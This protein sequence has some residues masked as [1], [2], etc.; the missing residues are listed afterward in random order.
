MELE[1]GTRNGIGAGYDISGKDLRIRGMKPERLV[2][3]WI[4][5]FWLF[6]YTTVFES[7]WKGHGTC[8]YRVVASCEP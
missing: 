1:P 6:F 5:A 3:V 2:A 7:C 8:N 4:V